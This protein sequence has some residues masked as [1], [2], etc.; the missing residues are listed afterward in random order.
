MREQ[1]QMYLISSNNEWLLSKYRSAKDEYLSLCTR[2]NLHPRDVSLTSMERISM[3]TN[4]RQRLIKLIVNL[5][6]LEKLMAPGSIDDQLFVENEANYVNS[7]MFGA[8]LN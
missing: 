7:G 1:R 8:A 3:K 5:I 6:D 4:D 2:Y